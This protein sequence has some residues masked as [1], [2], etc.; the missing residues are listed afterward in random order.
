MP[1]SEKSTPLSST[2]PGVGDVTLDE[3]VGALVDCHQAVVGGVGRGVV[4]VLTV[5]SHHAVVE[6]VGGRVVEPDEAEVAAE[7]AVVSHQPVV[8]CGRGDVE[9]ACQGCVM[10]G[11]MVGIDGTGRLV[12]V[13][14]FVGFRVVVG[15]FV[16]VLFVVVG[17]FEVVLLV[18]VTGFLV[19]VGGFLVVV[20]VVADVIGLGVVS[21]TETRFGSSVVCHHCVT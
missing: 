12:V 19:V 18:V 6:G 20:V 3:V 16:V 11:G 21:V 4:V 8:C 7:L 5:V 13:D 1:H 9:L 14:G 2:E 15:R 17:R 10:I